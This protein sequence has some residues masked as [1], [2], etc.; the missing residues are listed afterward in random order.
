MAGQATNTYQL[1]SFKDWVPH[2]IRFGLYMVILAAFQFSNGMYFTAMSQMEGELAVSM[3]DVKMMSHAVLIGL[4]MY[5]PLAF[6]LKF[7]FTNRTSLM[8]AA[9][10]LALCNVIVPHVDEPFLL[11]LLGF[12]AG[13][14]RLWGT[15][16]CFSNVLLIVAPTYNYAVF[17]SFV[18]MVVLGVI[19][20]FDAFSMQ[21]I[22][23]YSWQH[24]HALAIGLLLGV[25]LIAWLFM[26]PFRPMPKK[27][28]YGVDWLGGVLWSI[29]ILSLI[30][31]FQYGYQLEWFNSP[32]IRVALGA[33]CL[34]LA[35]NLWRMHYT[36]HP[37]L[38]TGAFQVRNLLN[39]LILFLCLGILLA[40]KN[41]L[42]NTFTGGVMHWDA[43]NLSRLKWVEFI[44]AAIGTLVS[45]YALARL[46]ASP[47]L[48]TFIGM[49]LVVG[50][51]AMMYFLLSQQMNIEKLFLP[52]VL[53]NAGH[54]MLFITLTV[55][56][57]ARAP[58][59][60]YFQVICILGFVR[61]GIASPIGD[62]IYQHAINGLM[63]KHLVAIGTDLNVSLLSSLA[64]L[65]SIGTEAM[66]ATLRELYG[67]TFIFGIV[68]LLAIAVSRFSHTMYKRMPS[69]KFLYKKLGD[70]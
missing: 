22:Y 31:I 32:Y 16:E 11:V 36:R 67:Y 20:L 46:K 29:L 57:Q 50:Y 47:K 7:C 48:M 18:F 45:W 19:H 42:L 49:S 2:P 8:M 53:C 34:A 24:V 58:F 4:T 56:I 61:T 64:N 35:A 27:P 15:F 37:F 6:R 60:V 69:L 68:V 70:A 17:L 65:N 10:G 66:V 44:G 12:I 21:L 41:V 38:E 1:M 43:I 54:L 33:A 28:L 39:L 9:T 40:S 14:C 5:F 3:D 59:T 25:I 52:L 62:A 30:F 51:V 26:R 23:Y 63:G 13:F 55:F